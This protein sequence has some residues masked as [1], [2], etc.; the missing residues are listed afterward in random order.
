MICTR[1]KA[2]RWEPTMRLV[3]DCFK[4]VKGKGKSIGIYN[5]AKTLAGHLAESNRNG[6]H[7]EEI[8][9]LGNE[10]NR[11]D[12]DIPGIRFVKM[13]G[14]PLNK[15]YCM[16]WE[17]FLV[18]GQA[19]RYGADRIL[20]PRGYRPAFYRGKD[21]VII[22][23]L[24][25]FFYDKYFPG[26][27]NR[28]ENAYIMSRLKASMKHADRIVTI[29]EF[30][31]QEVDA[32]C[33]GSGKR[34]RVIYNGVNAIA[35]MGRENSLRP[36]EPYLHAVTSGLPHKNAAGI[37]KTY[38][39]YF[40]QAADPLRLVLVGVESVERVCLE[41]GI[42]ISPEAAQAVICYRYIESAE[43]MHSL[44]AGARVF[45]FLSLIEGFGFPPVEAMQL[46]V[47]V[48]CSNRTALPEVVGDAGL[49]TD[50][51]DIAGTV[52]C[53]NRLVS[54][55]ELREELIRK[56]YENV[57]RFDWDSRTSQYWEVLAQ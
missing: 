54:D 48:I 8:I 12:F 21:T 19:R 41:N 43:E 47:P 9:V 32:M 25:P 52:E 39:A 15:V 51:E 50:P 33:P 37:L 2:R 28:V 40:R 6:E 18:P 23:D 35:D 20:F 16:I 36:E 14:N 24:I 1:A 13:K 34:V 5:L 26:V 55:E 29:S 31:R 45:L 17:L 3:I 27:L 30:S 42:R 7:C 46:G 4:L 53:I 49:L 10:Y 38:D 22:H 44:L 56:G 11:K 57:K